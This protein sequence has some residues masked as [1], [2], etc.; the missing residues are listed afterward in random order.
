MNICKIC[1]GNIKSEWLDMFDTWHECESCGENS[2]N[3]NHLI[4]DEE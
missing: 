4:N 2:I 1:G 3:I